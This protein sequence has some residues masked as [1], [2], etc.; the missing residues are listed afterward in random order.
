MV[1]ELRKI[2]AGYQQVLH[3]GGIPKGHRNNRHPAAAVRSFPRPISKNT[4][5]LRQE[6]RHH[7]P[8][9]LATKPGLRREMLPPNRRPHKPRVR[10]SKPDPAKIHPRLSKKLFHLLIRM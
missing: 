8:D 3:F 5:K 7:G 2:Q 4:K 9:K 6:F 10:P 1:A